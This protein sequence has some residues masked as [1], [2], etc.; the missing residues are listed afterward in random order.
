MEGAQ[1]SRSSFAAF[2]AINT[3]SGNPLYTG[4]AIYRPRKPH[5]ITGVPSIMIGVPDDDMQTRPSNGEGYVVSI[6]GEPIPASQVYLE[7]VPTCWWF[8]LERVPLHPPT[9]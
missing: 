1:P 2:V 5:P 9:V 8:I 7:R 4:E 6:S 3:I